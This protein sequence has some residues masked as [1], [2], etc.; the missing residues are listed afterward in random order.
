[1]EDNNNNNNN[2]GLGKEGGF[3]KGSYPPHHNILHRQPEKVAYGHVVYAVQEVSK[4]ASKVPKTAA[5]VPEMSVV[6]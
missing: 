2:G 3:A 5:I 6:V 1:V 4:T